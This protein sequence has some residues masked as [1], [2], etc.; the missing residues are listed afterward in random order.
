MTKSE[1]NLA[2][3]LLTYYSNKFEDRYGKKPNINKYKE[4]WA[5]SSILEDFEFDN[6]K[7]IID[8]YFTLSKEGH[9]LSWLFN[10]FDKLKDSVDSNEQDKIL[11]AERRAQTIK[12][13]EEWLNG[14]A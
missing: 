12:L 7:L 10:N 4:K 2:F 6:A 14:N 5:A 8:Y 11:R 13:R 3:A 9:P 1:A